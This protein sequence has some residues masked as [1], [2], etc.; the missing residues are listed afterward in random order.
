MGRYYYTVELCVQMPGGRWYIFSETIT[1]P[2][3][4][5][6]SGACAEDPT[7]IGYAAESRRAA[8]LAGLSGSRRE[9]VLGCREME[10]L[11]TLRKLRLEESRQS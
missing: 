1:Q 5:K 6:R 10:L 2:P 9:E 11:E 7:P 8:S 3:R 4:P